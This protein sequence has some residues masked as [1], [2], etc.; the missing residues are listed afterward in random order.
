MPSPKPTS[1]RSAERPSARLSLPVYESIAAAIVL[2]TGAK[3]V[4]EEWER[5][6]TADMLAGWRELHIRIPEENGKTTFEAADNLIHLIT[7]PKPR[8]VIAAR[9]EKQ[10]KILYLQ[11]VAMVSE[12]PELERRLAIREG[13]NEI[14]LKGRRGDVGLQVI[15]ADELSA[16]GAI[17]TRVTIDEMHALPGLG[18]YR[19]LS[20]K[21]GKRKDAQLIAI[22]TA[23]EPDSEY[24]QMWAGIRERA[25]RIDRH[26]PRCQRFESPQA[27][28]WEWALAKDD[29]P[30]DMETVKLAN[31]SS[32][33]TPA[34]LQA[35]RD[36]PSY[37]RKH[38]LT[39]V[40]NVPTRAFVLR[41]LAEGDWDAALMPVVDDIPEGAPII[42]GVDW[43]LTDDATVYQPLW[44]ED[45][46]MML[47]NPIIIEPPRNGRDLTHED[48]RKPLVALNERNPII[49]V[50]HDRE[51]IGRALEGVLDEALPEAEIV[52][53]SQA[54][55][56]HAPAYFNDQLRG[57]LLK[58]TG[59]ADLKRHLMNAIRVPVKNDPEKYRI[60]RPKASRHAPHERPIR[61][62]D[63][64][65]AAVNAV[66]AAVGREPV[67]EPYA[68]VV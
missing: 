55:A 15:P 43:G 32:F 26:G 52:P 47:G 68:F 25:T 22:S 24:E 44:Y 23:G 30:D 61:E 11:A 20:G 4:L 35:K 5:L 67:E 14:R 10:A 19:V 62:I 2:D 60:D 37:E 16:H 64:A 18:L 3:L 33:I 7:H 50:G 66:W 59:N 45:G 36:L 51:M 1:S 49:A 58:H 57:G 12:T 42:L 54:D 31:P 40:C 56:N 41:F 28:A 38:W 46:L 34:T 48:L 29:D 8:A 65:V 53:V 63:A 9:N 13:T 6:V 39:V 21:L 27:V 17:N